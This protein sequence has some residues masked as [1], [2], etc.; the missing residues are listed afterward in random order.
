[1]QTKKAKEVDTR[2]PVQ[3][4]AT[5]VG[6]HNG[7][8]Y[9]VGE[10]FTVPASMFDE[11]VRYEKTPMGPVIEAGVYD[12]PSWFEEGV[13]AVAETEQ[14]LVAKSA[15]GAGNQERRDDIG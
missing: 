1:M 5:G 11:R 4:V 13:P 15:Q 2:A 3:V 14:R 10:T 9:Q 12:P 8:M 6:Y 7:R